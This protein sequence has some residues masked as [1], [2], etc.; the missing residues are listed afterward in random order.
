ME[1]HGSAF[2]FYR[3]DS[4]IDNVTFYRYTL[5]NKNRAPFEEAYIGLYVDPDLGDFADDYPEYEGLYEGW[6]WK[7]DVTPPRP[8][9]P[10][11]EQDQGEPVLPDPDAADEDED[12]LQDETQTEQKKPSN[13]TLDQITLV[14]SAPSEDGEGSGDFVEIIMLLVPPSDLR[15]AAPAPGASSTLRR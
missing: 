3:P 7:L 10:P 6:E 1:V 8:L 13:Q 9:F 11:A 15:P 14:V 12:V 5:I 4:Y 2:A